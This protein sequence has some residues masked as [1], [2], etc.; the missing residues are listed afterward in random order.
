MFLLVLQRYEI[1]RRKKVPVVKV[2]VLIVLCL[3]EYYALIPLNI[4]FVG[5]K[6]SNERQ[7]IVVART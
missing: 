4:I 3:M 6:G 5:K 2:Y 7:W 1:I